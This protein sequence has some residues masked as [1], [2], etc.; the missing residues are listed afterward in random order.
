M[1][2]A[3]SS[4]PREI[5]LLVVQSRGASLLPFEELPSLVR[6]GDVWVVNDAATFPASLTGKTEAGA[7]VELRL[8]PHRP[9]RETWSAV[10]FGKGNWRTKTENREPPPR[11]Q[12]GTRIFLAEGLVATVREIADFSPRV[13]ECEMSA[14]EAEV[15][16]K[17]YR[18]GKPVQYAY[19]SDPLELDSVQTAYAGRPWASEMPSAGRP[20]SWN[21]LHSL[22]DRGASVHFLTHATGLSSTGEPEVDARLPFPEFFDIPESTVSA[23]L[24]A[25]A[26]GSRIIA[27]GTST[28]RALES[29]ARSA[30]GLR[31]GRGETDLKITAD[32]ERKIVDGILSGLHS[33]GESHFELLQS[34]FPSEHFANAMRLAESAKLLSHE[35]GD[36][37]FVLP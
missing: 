10:L 37:S 2:A 19:L 12:R 20:L 13:V 35:F 14:R 4:V 30:K 28:M 1:T 23:V 31:A 26:R 27:V 18:I 36:S 21:L 9:G 8:L 22:R 15:W 33:P 11:L 16:A 7:F 17:I 6:P 32:F 24:T 3:P 5:K 25:G 29:S 34:F